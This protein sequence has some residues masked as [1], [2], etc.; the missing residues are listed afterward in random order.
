M[1]LTLDCEGSARLTSESI[2]RPLNW[3]ERTAVSAHR[4]ICSKSRRLNRQLLEMHKAFQEQNAFEPGND[5]MEGL[6][7]DAKSRIRSA[8]SNPR[9]NSPSE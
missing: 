2:D 4:M 1:I 3:A 8:I 7:P 6:S 5:A 9:D